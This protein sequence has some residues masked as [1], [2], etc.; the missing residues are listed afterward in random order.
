MNREI[1]LLMMVLGVFCAI[2]GIPLMIIGTIQHIEQLTFLGGFMSVFG[3]LVTCTI[4][5]IN[6]K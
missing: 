5:I 1:W 6:K 3:C 2:A 4:S